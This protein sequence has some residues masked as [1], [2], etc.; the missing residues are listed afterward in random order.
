MPLLLYGARQVGKTYILKQFGESCYNNVVYFN[1]ENDVRARSVF[2]GNLDANAII[3]HLELLGQQRIIP[4][5]T[6]VVLDE[7]QA[8]ERAL[9]SLKTFCEN[10]P[11][12]HVAAAGSLM[13][14]AFNRERFSF[15]VGKVDEMTLYPMDFEE[16]LWALE[17]TALSEKIREHYLSSEKL[18]NALHDLALDCWRQYLVVGGM[19]GAVA[20][21]CRSR[22]FVEVADLQ[23]RV[24][25]DYVADM[26]KYATPSTSVKIRA[27]YNSIPAQLAKENRKFQYK[28]VQRG[29]SSA[30]FGEAIEWLKCAGVI[31]KCEK[32]SHGTVPIA[33]YSDL[34]DFKIYMSDVGLLTFKSG[35]PSS[36]LLSQLNEDNTFMG[37]VAEN[38]VAQ[39]LVASGHDV[40]YWRSDN[41]A[42]LDF[43][44]Q[45]GGNVIPIEVKKGRNTRSKSLSVFVGKYH[46]ELSLRISRKN[47]GEENGIKSVPLYA[48]F[49]I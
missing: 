28:V 45:L 3:S 11:Q 38:Y 42:E 16:F 6:L 47:F 49:C 4:G 21:Y 5:E 40:Y 48:A 25:N 19:P 18:A 34:A 23:S 46:P 41:T 39:S 32:V 12:F 36:I 27:C 24:L 17:Q 9:T 20:E 10:A 14:V 29:G 2:D 7:I 30:M 35:M 13:G 37:A 8:C 31:I 22:S 1:F 33:A 26:A 44:I 15:P 43:L